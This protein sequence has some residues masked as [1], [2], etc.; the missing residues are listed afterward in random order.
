MFQMVER[1][2]EAPIYA[3]AAVFMALVDNQT[4]GDWATSTFKTGAPAS[5]F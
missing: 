4:Y 5:S 2:P 3:G 1:P